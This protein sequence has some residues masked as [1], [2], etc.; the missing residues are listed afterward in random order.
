MVSISSP[1]F[2]SRISR[3]YWDVSS[4]LLDYKDVDPDIKNRAIKVY[5]AIANNIA[6]DNKPKAIKMLNYVL[7]HA[8]SLDIQNQ[9]LANLE[10]LSI[11]F[12]ADV[13]D[14]RIMLSF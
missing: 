1:K 5:V 13:A 11:N 12:D 6:S 14:E 2:I 7:S 9:I 10:K 3:Y 4:V 8:N